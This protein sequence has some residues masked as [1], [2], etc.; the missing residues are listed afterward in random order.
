MISENILPIKV[1]QSVGCVNVRALLEK[2][3]DTI[4]FSETNYCEVASGGYLILDFGKEYQGG[5]KLF[6]LKIDG[7]RQ[8]KVRI[9]FGESVME[10]CSD[11]GYK[12]STNDHSIRDD[13]VSVPWGGA[14]EYGMSGFRFCR[15]DNVDS[16][17]I[18]F[19]QIVCLYK[20][21]GKAI[22]G[23]FQCNDEEINR[24]WDASVRTIY[25]NNNEYVTDGIKRDRVVWIG[26]MYP[27]ASSVLKVFGNDESLLHSLDFMMDNTHLPE[28]MNDI[29]SYSL[30]WIIIL[31]KIY[32]YSG[33]KTILTDRFAYFEELVEMVLDSIDEYGNVAFRNHN[34]FMTYFI[35]WPS[36]NNPTAQKLGTYA[37]IVLALTAAHKI[38]DALQADVCQ[39]RIE[40]TIALIK[41]LPLRAC[42]NK[43]CTALAV[44]AGLLDADRTNNEV[45]SVGGL[46]GLSTFLGGFVM[47]AK[48]LAGDTN[49]ALD[50]VKNYYGGM[51]KVGATTL[52]EDFDVAWLERAKPIDVILQDGEYDIHGDNGGYCYEGYRNSMCHGWASGSISFLID[53]IIGLRQISSNCFAIAP[54]LGYLQWAQCEIP[55]HKG[56]LKIRCEK[57]AKGVSISYVAPKNVEI[58]VEN[59]GESTQK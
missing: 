14:L 37:L 24:V 21:S 58:I 53:D 34:D 25:L 43:Q 54:K 31:Q 12:N 6:A 17:S 27:E 55:T 11:I 59:K 50:I 39:C 44:C 13:I 22:L 47:Q 52:W 15:I 46:N 32:A 38:L 20:H 2:K 9:R 49:G 3:S 26:D 1:I 29:P 18:Y 41:S 16:V 23:K 40:K 5:V 19:T 35:D 45:L 48:M 28:W 51:L 36:S 33:D 10:A 4:L 42:D 57:Q 30:W 8:A 7:K 56:I